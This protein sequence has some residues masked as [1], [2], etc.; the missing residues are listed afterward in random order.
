MGRAKQKLKERNRDRQDIV[1][2]LDQRKMAVD[3][4]AAFCTTHIRT[5]QGELT[6]DGNIHA[7]S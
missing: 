4:A 2:S 1:T 3:V 6:A 7:A 5:D